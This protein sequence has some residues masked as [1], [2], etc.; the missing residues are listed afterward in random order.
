MSEKIVGFN[1]FEIK[2]K[3]DVI[4]ANLNGRL[5]IER[6]DQK[7]KRLVCPNFYS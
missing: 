3:N 5:G 4:W 1:N 6:L 2:E 7:I